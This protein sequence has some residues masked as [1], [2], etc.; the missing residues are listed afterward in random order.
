MPARARLWGALAVWLLIPIALPAEGAPLRRGDL[1][2][3][4]HHGNRVLRI[5][6]SGNVET[7][8]PPPGGTNHLSGPRGIT[9]VDGGPVFVVND[10]GLVVIDRGTGEQSVAQR[11]SGLGPIDVGIGA[12]GVTHFQRPNELVLYVSSME[13]LAI[14]SP[15]LDFGGYDSVLL[16]GPPFDGLG[17]GVRPTASGL[18]VEEVWIGTR[19]DGIWRWRPGLGFD[20]ILPPDPG[21]NAEAGEAIYGVEFSRE[22]L[23][24]PAFT[25]VGFLGYGACAPGTGGV[26]SAVF[27]V[28]PISQ[29]GLLRCP[30]GLALVPGREEIYV[31]EAGSIGLS[32]DGRIVR[33]SGNG[34]GSWTQSVFVDAATLGVALPADIA[35]VPEPATGAL[36]A[37]VLATLG[38]LSRRARPC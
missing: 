33:L 22:G 20:Q 17:V 2:V 28:G 37:A 6:R 8:S 14:V 30:L 25:K 24:A 36:G 1:L 13:G 34:A 18:D 23:R 9:V 38:A 21:A 4:D 29:G 19:S 27:G 3:T 32:D 5:D 35:L 12:W 31:T 15:N 11:S 7:F 26:F 10:G 16:A